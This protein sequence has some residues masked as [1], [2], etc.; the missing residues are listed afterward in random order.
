MSE[1]DFSPEMSPVDTA[2]DRVKKTVLGH[3]GSQYGDTR[4]YAEQ[5]VEGDFR[6]IY[7]HL[8]TQE[9]TAFD[10]TP[11]FAGEI[12]ARYQGYADATLNHEVLSHVVSMHAVTQFVSDRR[13]GGEAQ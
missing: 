7:H 4:E 13:N 1:E 6:A 3:M 12:L 2:W 5:D 11:D 9:P 10:N 8:Q